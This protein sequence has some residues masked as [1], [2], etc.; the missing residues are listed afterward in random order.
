MSEYGSS[1]EPV[2]VTAGSPYLDDDA[3]IILRTSNG[4][5][6]HVHKLV[7]SKCSP[8]FA[9]MFLLPQPQPPRRESMKEK[10]PVVQMAEDEHAL[11]LLLG[12]CYPAFAAAVLVLSDLRIALGLAKKYQMAQV[13][14]RLKSD[15][16]SHVSAEPERVFAIAWI[17]EMKDVAAT[18]ARQTL[19]NP[20]LEQLFEGPSPSEFEY[21]P[22]MAVY[23]LLQCQHLC[24]AAALEVESI[25][26]LWLS[27]QDA[28]HHPVFIVSYHIE[29]YECKAPAAVME[30][31]CVCPVPQR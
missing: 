19:A 15:L 16:L 6:F 21:A 3:D 26:R 23:K 4:V 13:W 11:R 28:G 7:L 14:E 29:P 9:D 30:S 2:S 12:F 20:G 5:D 31:G 8:V 24:T 1:A 17:F 18:A 22:A 10:L 27:K 25:S